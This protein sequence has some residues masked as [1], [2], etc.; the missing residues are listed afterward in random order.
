MEALGEK[1]NFLDGFIVIILD[2]DT[3]QYHTFDCAYEAL[4]NGTS[5][6]AYNTE[7]AEY[8]GYTACP[9]CHVVDEQ[10]AE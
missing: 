8:E 9:V 10:P 3:N 2:D 6:W 7:L 4:I 5:F 1:A